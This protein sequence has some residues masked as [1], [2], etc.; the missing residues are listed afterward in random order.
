MKESLQTT[1]EKI[2]IRS[3][4]FPLLTENVIVRNRK[5]TFSSPFQTIVLPD[6]F[7]LCLSV[8]CVVLLC[9]LQVRAFEESSRCSEHVA[10]WHSAQKIMHIFH[11]DNALSWYM[12]HAVEMELRM[13]CLNIL[14]PLQD[15]RTEQLWGK[16]LFNE[17]CY[18]SQIWWHSP[19]TNAQNQKNKT[20]KTNDRKKMKK[21]ENITMQNAFKC[22]Y[23][24]VIAVAHQQRVS[25]R[26]WENTRTNRRRILCIGRVCIMHCHGV[27]CELPPLSMAGTEHSLS[28]V[29]FIYI[30][31]WICK[32]K[33]P[34]QDYPGHDAVWCITNAFFVPILLLSWC[35]AWFCF[36]FFFLVVW[37][38]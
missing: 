2:N 37:D 6:S 17:R 20:T 10:R 26:A 35:S 16:Q 32:Y 28:A 7:L 31:I 8:L 9:M 33:L 34:N 19:K 38:R 12:Q 36:L 14:E 22:V 4:S 30:K 23:S 24:G 18:A 5:S 3:I 29:I 25:K 1:I 27:S 15:R 21:E 11:G 13:W